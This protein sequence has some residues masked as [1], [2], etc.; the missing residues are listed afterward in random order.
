MAT[1][2][3]TSDNFGPAMQRL[4]PQEQ[5]F[6]CMLFN[7]PKSM[8]K[9]AEMAG[10]TSDTRN[11]LRVKAHRLLRRPEVA[12]AVM[13]ETKRRTIFLMPKAQRALE[14][15]V[16]APTHPDHF[17]AIKTVREESGLS[18]VQRRIMDVNVTHTYTEP[19]KMERIALFAK[20]H[21]IPL[22]KL[23]GSAAPV[24]AEFEELAKTGASD[25]E[26]RELGIID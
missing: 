3:V 15:L 25:A 4:G 2:L 23:I 19:E 1:A 17:K 22:Q 11:G 13:E 20:E 16:D 8:T 6:V 12:E 10:I 5:L 18:A 26:L 14:N 24:D 7:S 9:A 21:G